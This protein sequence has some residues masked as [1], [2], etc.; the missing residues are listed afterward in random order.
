MLLA[1]IH[2]AKTERGCGGGC[3]GW[4][5]KADSARQE[6]D[7]GQFLQGACIHCHCTARL[8]S[9][10]SA[11]P[12]KRHRKIKRGAVAKGSPSR[13]DP[14]R[15]ITAASSLP[16]RSKAA[17]AHL[18][19]GQCG[20]RGRTRPW[21]RRMGL[22]CSGGPAVH[23]LL[24]VLPWGARGHRA[25]VSRLLT[26]LLPG[27]STPVGAPAMLSLSAAPGMAERGGE[28]K[29]GG[30]GWHSSPVT[31][32]RTAQLCP[33]R[34]WSHK[35]S[36]GTSTSRALGFILLSGQP[37]P[38]NSPHPL[39]GPGAL[40]GSRE[41]PWSYRSMMSAMVQ[42]NMRSPSGICRATGKRNSHG[43]RRGWKGHPKAGAS[44]RCSHK[45]T[46]PNQP[47]VGQKSV[48]LWQVGCRMS[49]LGPHPL[50]LC[51]HLIPL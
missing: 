43:V 49:C 36:H 40:Q 18:R 34:L 41:K 1:L 29:Q 23:P 20:W 33:A 3:G 42:A 50:S 16:S 27:S 39:A 28:A 17:P 11:S 47:G 51:T 2:C 38:R 4:R 5:R 37:I 24:A 21:G 30:L 8:L 44:S 14:F 19:A 48:W 46:S 45:P 9:S 31:C 32:R 12:L 26:R 7:H 13:S 10:A 6:R 25:G 15:A 35:G 22:C